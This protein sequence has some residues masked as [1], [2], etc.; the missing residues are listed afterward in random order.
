[1]FCKNMFIVYCA[2]YIYIIKIRY[3]FTKLPFILKEN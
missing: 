2:T 1:M 3:I